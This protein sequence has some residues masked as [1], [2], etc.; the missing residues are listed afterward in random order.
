M[1]FLELIGNRNFL[2]YPRDS[3]ESLKLSHVWDRL[4]SFYP[5]YFRDG[6]Y[7][8]TEIS[9]CYVDFRSYLL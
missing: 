5:V 7:T 4:I 1:F 6:K 9:C 8:I 2:I 3:K